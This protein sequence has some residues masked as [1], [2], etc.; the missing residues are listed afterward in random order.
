MWIF[1]SWE[2]KTANNNVDNTYEDVNEPWSKRIDKNVPN[3]RDRSFLIFT[4]F[5]ENY[6]DI[7]KCEFFFPIYLL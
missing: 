2:R 5:S 1:F 3:L 7:P 6:F 4:S